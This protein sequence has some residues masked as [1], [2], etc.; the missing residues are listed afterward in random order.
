MNSKQ[1]LLFFLNSSLHKRVGAEGL[2][3]QSQNIPS[4]TSYCISGIRRFRKRQ[5]KGD[6]I[7][8]R[9]LQE[10]KNACCAVCNLETK[11]SCRRNL[12][13]CRKPCEGCSGQMNWQNLFCVLANPSYLF[14]V[15]PQLNHLLFHSII[16]LII[17]DQRLFTRYIA[18]YR[19]TKIN[20]SK[21]LPSLRSLSYRGDRKAN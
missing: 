2:P 7:I 14:S 6:A 10:R 12:A 16:H 21:S 15:W 8:N 20:N 5:S 1:T 18:E 13:L 17:V 4:K 11:C 3:F 19:N 9:Q